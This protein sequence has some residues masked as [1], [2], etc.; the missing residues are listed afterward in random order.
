MGAHRKRPRVRGVVLVTQKL[1]PGL[2]RMRRKRVFAHLHGVLRAGNERAGFRVVA[3]SVL[4]N[5]LHLLVEVT[6]TVGLSRGM[7]GLGVRVAKALN[8]CWQ[9]RGKVFAERFHAR[10]VKGMA[11]MR[12]A[13]VYVLQNARRHG[14][15]LGPL[16][17]DPWSSAPWFTG[18]LEHR[19]RRRSR[20]RV[21]GCPVAPISNQWL[22]AVAL[23]GVSLREVPRCVGG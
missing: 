1:L 5:H 18:W 13:V 9:R 16:E 11:S 10:A 4:S 8:R 22:E 21:E 14:V 15:R 3:F 12:R 6:S 17:P 19:G 2:P 20:T 7:Q 23:Q